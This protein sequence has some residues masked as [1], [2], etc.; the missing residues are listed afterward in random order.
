M[1]NDHAEIGSK[2]TNRPSEA[3]PS[4]ESDSRAL[5]LAHSEY[6]RTITS[7]ASQAI[8]G[9][10]LP[11]LFHKTISLVAHTL[12]LKYSSIWQVLSDGDTLQK[13]ASTGWSNLT[14]DCLEISAQNQSW[15]RP[16]LAAKHPIMI[17]DNQIADPD[18]KHLSLILPTDSVS[19][20]CM[21]IPG[22]ESPLGLLTIHSVESRR[23][24]DETIHFLKTVAHLLAAAIERKRAES[25]LS[26]QTQILED[27]ASG[28]NLQMVYQQICLLLEQQAPG[29]L[30]S[31]LLVDQAHQR[32]QLG[33]APSMPQA[34]I[35]ALDGLILGE[36]AGSCGTAAHQKET[37]FVQDIAKDPRWISFQALALKHNIRAC[38]SS[39]FFSQS[40]QV[41]GTVALA[42]RVSC[43]P[44]AHHLEIM[45]TA[46]H[47]AG[48]AAEG[49]LAAEQ[50]KQQTLCD[51]LTGLS[52]CT[53]F[54]E[55]LQR[56]FQAAHRWPHQLSESRR[57][58]AVLFLDIDHFKL[59][60]DSLGYEIGDQLLIALSRRLERCL[61]PEDT[62]TRLGG[63]EFALLLG[64]IDDVA[65]AR[66][67][68]DRIQSTLSLPFKLNAHELFISVTVGIALF[69][70]HHRR[71][72]DLLRDADIAMYRAK[73]N[74][75]GSHAIFDQVMQAQVFS[76]SQLE[77]E[78]RQE[79]ES[80]LSNSSARFQLYYQ[81]IVSFLT[82]SI[83]GF[84]AL[85]RWR[86]PER[87]SLPPEEFIP[88]AEA[89]GLIVPIGKWI[90]QEAC[91]QLRHWQEK[92]NR[93]NSLIMSVNISNRQL[94][95]PD[96]LSQIKEVL[97]STQIHASSLKLEITETML[98]EM[99]RFVTPQLE[100]LHQMGIQLNLDDFGTGYSSLSYLHT[101]P[102]SVL[103]IDRSFTAG[104]GNKHDQI[105]RT[106]I[107]LARELHMDTIAE[108]I[109]THQQIAQLREFGCHF[110]QGYLFSAPIPKEEA[111][112]LLS[113]SP[114]DWLMNPEE[115]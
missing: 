45:K 91:Q 110:G 3:I 64:A 82:G 68:A 22:R 15:V 86:H 85:V 107:S 35:Q 11:N 108:G 102:V 32:L 4:Q 37:V 65:Q 30:C 79:L 28:T 1:A 61:Q 58:F 70:Q 63:D 103:K 100:S 50:L 66:L 31:I 59:V 39:P 54:M 71:P 88:V 90:L 69:S 40:G 5:Q 24:A 114:F 97:G 105:I 26:I 8:S 99:A 94:L 72:E 29:A 47:L 62:L 44:S 49:H 12:E 14:V 51:P 93:F 57:G 7:L 80:L 115:Y 81:P 17:E 95:Q 77:L 112:V 74:E 46:T 76:R 98:M 10:E 9:V 101:I 87:G 84:E 83:I 73:G 6:Q 43:Q 53:L 19:S 36:Q 106:I 92:L 27:I 109:E 67:V 41:L 56:K 18:L 96:F 33:A 60:N 20:V 89:N 38:W 113:Q 78:L 48:L 42:H 16:L 2:R 21:L 25:L 23:F 52:N 55:R 111:E 13:V 75:R 104:L 34:Y